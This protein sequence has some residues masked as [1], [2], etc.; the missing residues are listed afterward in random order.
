MKFGRVIFEIRADRQTYTQLIAV[1]HIP[2]RCG[3]IK[4]C[5]ACLWGS[6]TRRS[7][8]GSKAGTG[9]VV[10]M[11]SSLLF[12]VGEL[13]CLL[14]WNENIFWSQQRVSPLGNFIVSAE[15]S[16]RWP[17]VPDFPGQ[18]RFL[19]TC[20]WKKTVFPGCPFVPFLAWCPRFVLTLT[21][22]TSLYAY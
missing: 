17:S 6:P 20:P 9:F 7:V 14:C 19:T 5:T 11:C 16:V 15:G 3:V 10:L 22:C 21:N 13:V 1:L 12:S 8:W 4:M 2:T 18:S